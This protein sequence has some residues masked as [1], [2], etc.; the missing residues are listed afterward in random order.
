MSLNQSRSDKSETHFRK[1][2][3]S[4]SSGNQQR[5]FSGKGGGSGGGTAPPPAPSLSSNRSYKKSNNAQGAQSRINVPSLNQESSN[6][7][8]AQPRSAQNGAQ[9]LPHLRGVS[10]APVA[11]V[12]AKPT[13]SANHKGNR[14]LPKAPS[15]QPA[16]VSSDTKAPIISVKAPADPSRMVS[17]QF[18]TINFLNGM[19][20]PARTSS[21]PPN[22]DEQ[23]REQERHDSS[24]PV[25]T[26][27]TP[28]PK[29]QAPRK[30]VGAVDQ[31]LPRK[32]VCVVEQSNTTE[33]HSMSNVKRD[34]QGSSLPPSTHMQKPS[35]PP[36]TGISVQMPFHQQ[37]VPVQFGGPSP[38]ILSQGMTTTSIQ[39]PMPMPLSM[40]NA[41][42]IQ[43]Q[44]FVSG[45]QPHH[46][47]Q[48]QGIM[49]QGQSMGFTNP[50]N[51]QLPS[52]LGNLVSMSP[53]FT[54]Q[55]AG[56][57]G[58]PRKSVGVKITN[59]ETRE[60]VRL[61]KRADAY[62]DGGSSG[63]RSHSNVPLQSQPIQSFPPTHPYYHSSFNPYFSSQNSVPLTSSQ[64]NPSSQGTRFNYPV[65][66]GPQ[67]L[68][69]MNPT[70]LNPLSGNK[71]GHPISGTAE[72]PKL[73]HSRDLH[74]VISSAPS[75]TLPVSIK[76]S[77]S[78]IGN[79]VNTS[80]A[81]S[82][83][84]VG[85]GDMSNLFP[86]QRY[87]ENYSENS[88][89]QLKSGLEVST[90]TLGSVA[91]KQPVEMPAA[92][93]MESSV[94]PVSAASSGEFA[95]NGTEG[96][97]RENL[98]R[99]NSIKEHQKKTGKKG[100]IHLPHQVGS[101]STSLGSLPS[102][103]LEHTASSNSEVSESMDAEISTDLSATSGGILESASESMS[104]L[105]AVTSEVS[106]G[107]SDGSTCELSKVSG[108][109][110]FSDVMD[111]I[112]YANQDEFKLQDEQLKHDTVGIEEQGKTKLTEGT[113]NDT[114]SSE[115]LP[116]SISSMS[117]EV[118]KRTE[119]HAVL[120]ETT[121]SSGV[122]TL[123][124]AQGELDGSKNYPTK[125]DRM[126]DNLV[127]S[128][129]P[130]SDLLN[131]ETSQSSR[132]SSS[133]SHGDNTLTLDA[134]SSVSDSMCIK[135]V[136]DMKSGISDSI[137]VS[138]PFYSEAS[139]KDEGEG[140]ES[141]SHG[142]VFPPVAGS[143]DKSF[144]DPNKGK[145]NMAKRRKRKEIL[146]K[147][148]AAGTT[149][150]LYLAYKG[151]EEKK[152]TV[153]SSKSTEKSSSGVDLKHVSA[154]ATHEHI[155]ASEKVVQSK[156]E[157]DD[158][159]DA[160]D[161]STPKLE[162]SEFGE[163][164]L[165]HHNSNG[166]EVMTK[167]YS[168]DF[169]LKFAE[170]CIDLPQGLEITSDIE[171]LI[172]AN[173][174]ASNFVDRDLYPSPGRNDRSTGGSRS[175]RRGNITVDDE[176]WNKG[177]GSFS[178]GR[179]MRPEIGYGGNV[180]GFRSGQGVNYVVSRNSRAQGPAHY[181]AGGILSPPMQ[182]MGPQGVMQRNSSD[183]DRWQRATGFQKGLI[184]SPHTPLQVMHRAERK[185]EVGKVTD[186]EQ[187]K[188][189][190]LKAILNK[191]TPQ[192]FEKLFEQV[193]AVNIDNAI[194]LT[195][196]ISQIFDK[197][198]ME[199]TFCEMYANFCHHLAAELPD[200]S[201]DNEKITFKRMLLNKCQ[202]EFE[203]GERE[204]EEANRVEEGEIKQSPEEREEKR[205]Q[206]RRRMLGNIRLIG[207]LYK[208][209]MLTE[210][211]MHECI[212]KLLGQYQNPDEEDIEALCKLMSTIGEM[213]D[214][215]KAK[216]HIDAYFDWMSKLS[217]NMK[218]SSRVRFMLKDSIDLRRNKWQQR[219]KVEGPKKIEEVHR[220]A[221][222]ERQLVGRLSRGPSMN[223][224]MRRGPP[225][226]FAPRGSTML[227]SPNAQMGGFR[228][229]SAHVRGYNQDVRA[230]ERPT[231]LP[232]RP[233]GDDSITLGPQ[234][235]LGRGMSRGPPPSVT[236]ADIP[237]SPGDFR[238][239]A[240]GLN[241]Y[242]SAVSERT[243]YSLREEPR[244]NPVSPSGYDQSGGQERNISYGARSYS[245]DR[246]AVTSPP[247]RGQGPTAQNVPPENVVSEERLQEMSMTAIKEFYSAN[248]VNEV[249]LCIKDLNSPSFY[250]TMIYLWVTDSFERKDIERDLFAKL[251]VNLSKAQDGILSQGHLLKGFES[252]LFNLEDAVNDAPRAAEF[253]GRIFAKVIVENVVSLGDIGRLI[254]RGGDEP[255]RLLE[256]GLAGDVLGSVLESIQSD[257]GDL[258]LKDIRSSSNLQLEDF[259]PPDPIKSRKL[260]KFII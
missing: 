69:F 205:V 8:A 50:M 95:L 73:E 209:R 147:A 163:L 131:V 138:V 1:P 194:T 29:Q 225:M 216:E 241:G 110:N 137:S 15:S 239:T 173:V 132:V 99:S 141:I 81:N 198:L 21:A 136:A 188:Q 252:V 164:G 20:I 64:I 49:H 211:I 94:S 168:R 125:P 72:P 129:S 223:S 120:K 71:T 57:F 67:T 162:T 153:I 159:E 56:K 101:Q 213:I 251:L 232:Q 203:R 152:E 219:R 158:W 33:A 48:A 126:S 200:F 167:K 43:Q 224:S 41:S 230:D 51:S 176:K 214:H 139:L 109:G 100:H 180:S 259:R 206:A 123:K 22:L 196:V 82:S 16:T 145:I 11:G 102:R 75:A 77:A 243:A 177:P 231:Y 2:G 210:R 85:R 166:N 88:S 44:V 185:Y 113:H 250:P 27:P 124:T 30:D 6:V 238:R 68:S 204:Q 208:K 160:A 3:R 14:I 195:G 31:Q 258:V 121:N 80:L 229:M 70:A 184:P 13:E 36:M 253:L 127:K 111:D 135:E 245:S 25:P 217:N 134:Y 201:E 84:V 151:P 171:A 38:Q 34:A 234:G 240:A 116:E 103:A 150:D 174:N 182:S 193:K 260:E 10:D 191:L 246:P 157:P 35:L 47:M 86:L 40:G 148:D 107:D 128:S 39:M 140:A 65:S 202:E 248:D 117:Q 108:A 79:K 146:Q 26:L 32:D 186:E 61:E 221:A 54:Q 156:A 58:G 197:A 199:P 5:S 192:N 255:G 9:P 53:Q 144:I 256:V 175:D 91:T 242:G 237:P 89:Q 59:P 74:I 106:K 12:S 161:I 4:G 55:Q 104:T 218:L 226:D 190:Q 78:S 42:Q 24:R 76:H 112:H 254:H 114:S 7:S 220:D 118:A 98:S 179:D 181:S 17:L 92:V 155:L 165:I 19:Q 178:L 247:A 105:G 62:L 60:E 172:S 97:R 189:R 149:S 96:R 87:S 244:Y 115:L 249:S 142:L 215:P 45:L 154:D 46:S 236:S 257:K 207:E 28:A 227:S 37:K 52:Q 212:Q 228:G 93:S 130:I 90:S 23:K 169:L 18:G 235:G 66:Q 133:V 222:Q 187:A 170:Q 233:F 122:G 83:P 183:S 119:E 143:K 63:Q